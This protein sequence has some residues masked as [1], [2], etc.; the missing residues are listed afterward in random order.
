MK[1]RS[2]CK[3][4]EGSL[5]KKRMDPLRS[6]IE[7]LGRLSKGRRYLCTLV[8]AADPGI[9]SMIGTFPANYSH[10]LPEFPVKDFFAQP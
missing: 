6:A 7:R 3:K 4:R 9:L 5:E 8:K 2:D 10:M 1:G